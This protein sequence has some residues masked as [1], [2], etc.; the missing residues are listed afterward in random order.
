MPVK[1][2]TAGFLISFG[3]VSLNGFYFDRYFETGASSETP[4]AATVAGK[5]FNQK[6]FRRSLRMKLS[7]VSQGNTRENNEY[8]PP[9]ATK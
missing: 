1:R 6:L 5:T 9:Q 4:I 3:R 2:Y 7:L 8:I